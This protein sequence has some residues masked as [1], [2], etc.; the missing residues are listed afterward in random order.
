MLCD[1]VIDQFPGANWFKWYCT[2]KGRHGRRKKEA[3][4]WRKRWIWQRNWKQK[5]EF[6]NV[7]EI[8]KIKEKVEDD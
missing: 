1:I 7:I 2:I 4:L 5:D 8:E 3:D 6:G